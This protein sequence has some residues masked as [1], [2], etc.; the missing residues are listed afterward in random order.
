MAD[1]LIWILRFFVSTCIA[2]YYMT[3][4]YLIFRMIVNADREK[5]SM[6]DSNAV[7]YSY[8]FLGTIIGLQIFHS[9]LELVLET[10]LTIAVGALHLSV[11]LSVRYPNAG[12]KS[13]K[14]MF[15]DLRKERQERIDRYESKTKNQRE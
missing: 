1:I 5:F 14:Y 2:W 12:I 13:F 11:Y 8:Y 4:I 9:D 10:L 6:S 7:Q 3:L 15:R